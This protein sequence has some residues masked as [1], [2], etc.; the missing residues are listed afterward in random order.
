LIEFILALLICIIT[1]EFGHLLMAVAL[2]IKVKAYSIGFGKPLFKKVWKGIE[3]RIAPI[4]LGGYCSLKGEGSRKE[5]D[6]FLNHPYWKKFLVIIAGCTVNI[7]IAFICYL[8]NWQ[9]IKVGLIIDWEL[10]KAL[11][12]HQQVPDYI[13]TIFY[14][15]NPSLFL[16]QLGIMS[17][18]CGIVNLAPLPPL[19]GG[20]IWLLAIEKN[21]SEWFKNVIM[22]LG[23]AVLI[24]SQA[25]LICYLYF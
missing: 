2:G 4:L 5:L 13:L 22:V 18:S 6:D 7:L 10:S 24:I 11:L 3:W 14:H 1:H 19:D 21:M 23:W 16:E 25:W 15:I 12:T 8:I 9:S 17:I 20:L